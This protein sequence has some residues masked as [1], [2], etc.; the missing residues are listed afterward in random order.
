MTATTVDAAPLAVDA[1][2]VADLLGCS[3]RH[4][5][6][7]NAAG[8]LPAPKRI[9]GCVRWSVSEI[10]AWLEAGCPDRAMWETMQNG[11]TR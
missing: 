6:R 5:R 8:K 11:T 1:K 3:K 10:E 9:G 7:M 2:R 4:I